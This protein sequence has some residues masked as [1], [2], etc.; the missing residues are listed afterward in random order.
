MLNTYCTGCHNS[1]APSGGIALE[2]YNGV[3]AV[4]GNGRLLGAITHS[5][6][7]SPMPKNGAKLADCQIRQVQKWVASGAPN[8]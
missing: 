8:N 6:G 2:N 7:Y 5:A 1:A 4:A 3:Q